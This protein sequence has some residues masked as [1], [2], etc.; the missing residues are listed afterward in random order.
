MYEERRKI[1]DAEWEA[2]MEELEL[3]EI[4]R[5]NHWRQVMRTEPPWL[6]KI[7]KFSWNWLFLIKNKQTQIFQLEHL[8]SI[9][10]LEKSSF[11]LFDVSSFVSQELKKSWILHLNKFF[12]KCSRIPKSLK[13]CQRASFDLLSGL[14]IPSRK[15]L[16][17]AA[18]FTICSGHLQ[19]YQPLAA[20]ISL[21]KNS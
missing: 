16:P 4:E 14:P 10:K 9:F 17:L 19:Q 12:Q 1:E 6:W 3:M 13:L 2:E 8:H 7:I 18:F 5:N 21:Q 20:Q 11:L 15:Y